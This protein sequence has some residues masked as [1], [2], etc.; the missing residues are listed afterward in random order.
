MKKKLLNIT[1]FLSC[2]SL[3]TS[4]LAFGQ[5]D[6][7][8]N[9]AT[10]VYVVMNGG[11]SATPI[12]LV[13]NNGL[14]SAIKVTG[15][16]AQGGIVSESEFNMIWW[17][18]GTNTGTYVIPFQYSTI[19]YLPLTFNNTGGAGVGSGT[20]KFS[21]YHTIADQKI[22]VTSTTGMPSDVTN[23]F[24]ATS[25]SS[26]S[27][28]DDSYYVVDRFWVID[29]S[30]GATPYTTKPSPI[31]TF[32]YNNTGG[33]SEIAAPN[34]LTETNLEAQRFNSTLSMGRLVWTFRYR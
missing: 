28:T 18:I 32:S 13:L 5:A 2:L 8:I 21:T 1:F 26:P 14:S 6:F 29:A 25:T 19:R 23:M 11:T 4:K 20:I 27:A 7:V 9:K 33:S 16:G 3:I 10:P 30:G 24:P 34:V 22:G 17:N 31:L 12:Y 15:A